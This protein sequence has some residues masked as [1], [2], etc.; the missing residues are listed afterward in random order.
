MNSANSDSVKIFPPS[1]YIKDELE[2]RG[3]TQTDLAYILGRTIKDTND[4]VIGL[5]KITPELAQELAAVFQ[6]KAQYWLELENAYKLAQTDYV[7]TAIVKRA[8]LFNEYPAKEMLRRGWIEETD[9]IDELERRFLSFF[10]ETRMVGFAARKSSSYVQTSPIQIAWIIRAKKLAKAVPTANFDAARLG[11][12]KKELR[13]LAAKSQA[14]IRVPELLASYG[15]R[16]VVVEILPNA[17]IDGATFWLDSNS[18]VIAMSLRFDNIGSFWFTLMHEISHIEH[19]DRF[20]LDD[21]EVSPIDEIEERANREAAESLVP[22]DRIENFVKLYSPYYSEARVNN[23]ATQ[24]KIHPGIIVGQLH[25][26]KEI[27][28]NTLRKAMV[29]IRD[30]ITTTAFTDGWNNP[31]P[32]VK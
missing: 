26:R 13:R 12:L 11:Q 32:Q 5:R 15:I 25:Y 2:K 6:T 7:D 29:K 20:F 28:Y 23:L 4:I 21:L 3:W 22:Q 30:I 18:P 31:I 1:K 24:L 8:Q 9:D 10:S 17:K 27:G 14:V 19:K 16:F